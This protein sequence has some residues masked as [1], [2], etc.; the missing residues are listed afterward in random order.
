MKIRKPSLQGT[1]IYAMILGLSLVG[2]LCS[3]NFLTPDNL[4]NVLRPITLLG[5]V[6]IG[7]AFIALSGHYVDLSIP[8]LMALT[9]FVTVTCL[10]LGLGI[11]IAAGLLSG[12]LVGT[13][14][15]LVIGFLRVN[16]I[17][18]TLGTAFTLDGLLRWIYSGN[19]VYPNDAS[20]PGSA[21][22]QLARTDLW[23]GLPL[24]TVI[25]VGLAVTGQWLLKRTRYGRQV[26]LTGSSIEVA[27]HSGVAVQRIV[28]LTFLLSSFTTAVAG[29][30]LTSLSK[31]G[32]FQNGQGYDFNAVTAVVLGGISLAGGEGSIFGA[33]AGVLLIGLLCNIM[34][35]MGV[36]AFTQM[37]VK[38]TVFIA[39]VGLGSFLRK[40]SGKDLDDV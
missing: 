35:L 30:F 5:I 40:R 38:G 6:S 21:F 10:P 17:L 37:M 14:N 22:V 27:R 39:A 20:G 9:G 16:P 36:D 26:R 11:S 34:T 13:I 28:F 32:T 2:A 23:G 29:I 19:Q 25:L 15:G 1:S 18:W 12:V 33:M 7:V 24:M 31:L 8:S 3:P 4:L